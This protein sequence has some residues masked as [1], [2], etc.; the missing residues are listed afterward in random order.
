MRFRLR[1][2]R[3]VCASRRHLLAGKTPYA[4]AT[5]GSSCGVAADADADA[6]CGASARAVGL[7]VGLA[8]AA[9]AAAAAAAFGGCINSARDPRS[10]LR[11]SRIGR[12]FAAPMYF[13]AGGW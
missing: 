9:A 1:M 5:A 12:A 2:G 6:S 4:G 10:Q 11:A 3:R 8:D 13:M 7:A